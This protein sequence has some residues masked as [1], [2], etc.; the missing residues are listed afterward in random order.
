M[1]S[2]LRNQVRHCL[3][4]RETTLGQTIH[5]LNKPS[6]EV[7]RGNSVF[8]EHDDDASSPQAAPRP[9][10][11][12]RDGNPRLQQLY[13]SSR[14]CAPAGSEVAV[15]H[16]KRVKAGDPAFTRLRDAL[17]R[18]AMFEKGAKRPE[19]DRARQ[20]LGE[21]D[22]EGDEPHLSQK[23][24]RTATRTLVPA[25]DRHQVR[26][27]RKRLVRHPL[28]IVRPPRGAFPSCSHDGPI[29]ASTRKRGAL[30]TMRLSVV[31]SPRCS[32]GS[33]K[34]TQPPGPPRPR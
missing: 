14:S 29:E 28:E 13:L 7:D 5:S 10:A 27:N 15:N 4:Y 23:A 33:Y 32:S 19:S 1:F 30:S 25:A 8:V 34:M 21:Q 3:S 31:F 26:R 12:R 11:H 2:N 9:A 22:R 16:E 20:E 18:F 17:E 24:R 6:V